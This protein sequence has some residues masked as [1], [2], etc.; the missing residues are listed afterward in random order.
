LKPVANFDCVRCGKIEDLPV[1]CQRCPYC[2]KKRGFERLYD[3][4]NVMSGNTRTTGK[5]LEEKL[6]PLYERHADQQAGAKR[7]AEASAEAM[8]KTYE[9]ATPAERAQMQPMTGHVLPAG[10]VLSSMSTQARQDTRECITPAL[11]NRRVKPA[12]TK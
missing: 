8:E 4:I 9:K 7:F 6:A 10:G 12:W 1:D 11:L 5:V 2:G 3:S